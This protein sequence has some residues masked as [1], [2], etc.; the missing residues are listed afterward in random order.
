MT[1]GVD[2]GRNGSYKES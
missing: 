2:M 1:K